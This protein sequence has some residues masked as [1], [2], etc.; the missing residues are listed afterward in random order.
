MDDACKHEYASTFPQRNQ[1]LTDRKVCKQ[2]KQN[3]L[4]V[5]ASRAKTETLLD[6]LR[7]RGRLESHESQSTFSL[8]VAGGRTYA[9]DM[10]YR[11]LV[12]ALC[13]DDT[14]IIARQFML[15]P[16]V[17]DIGDPLLVSLSHRLGPE[18]T[19]VLATSMLKW[20]PNKKPEAC[21]NMIQH[22][23]ATLRDVLADLRALAP[24]YVRVVELISDRRFDQLATGPPST[25][26]T[27]LETFF[28][29]SGLEDSDD[30]FNQ[31]EDAPPY[32]DTDS[33]SGVDSQDEKQCER[34]KGRSETHRASLQLEAE[35]KE[36]RK[37][38]EYVAANAKIRDAT[39]AGVVRKERR[40]A[41]AAGL[42]LF[43]YEPCLSF[44]A[45]H[46]GIQHKIGGANETIRTMFNYIGMATAVN[47]SN[48]HVRL[49]RDDPMRQANLDRENLSHF[50]YEK[51]HYVF[52]LCCACYT[53]THLHLHTHCR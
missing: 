35:D 13:R 30:E 27:Q 38:K 32:E 36:R 15:L 33:D 14:N 26:P 49:F 19:R 29:D 12:V 43:Q 21:N 18:F 40:L 20:T 17:Q 6:K 16:T 47:T 44:V 37:E 10:K 5:V 31:E 23:G 8:C 4:A 52:S 22:I 50:L 24:T 3:L 9:V 39:S 28:T 34:R 25:A 41:Y 48:R 42:L 51:V 7:Q 1:T 45:G 2:C 11:P 46:A 53:H